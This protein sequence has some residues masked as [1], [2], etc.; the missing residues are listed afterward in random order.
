MAKKQAKP[1]KEPKKRSPARADNIASNAQG[2]ENN[3]V[4]MLS[5]R[6]VDPSSSD[7]LTNPYLSQIQRQEVARNL[8]QASGNQHLHQ[9]L[10]QLLDNGQQPD[11]VQ[12]QDG[13]TEARGGNT[14]EVVAGDSLWRIAENTYGHGRYWRQIY[15]ANP[16][17]AA[18]G[19]NLIL[20]GTLLTLPLLQVP[21]AA[22]AVPAPADG[23]TEP[24]LGPVGISTEFGNFDIYPDEFVGPLPLSV[25]SA[26]S[27]PIRQADFDNMMTR[28]TEVRDNASNL[29]IT[30]TDAFKTGVMLDLGWLMTS[31]VGQDLVREIQ[32]SAHTVTIKQGAG[33]NATSYSP[34]AD[35]YERPVSPPEAGPGANVTISYNPSILFIK[36][37]SLAWHHRPPAIGLAHEM[38]HAWTGVYGTRALYETAGVKRRELQATGLDEFATARLSEN[39]FRVA[40]GLPER[41]VY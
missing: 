11:A 14:Y 41:P 9:L 15:V 25:R 20:I 7:L 36:D 6:A 38:V 17:K 34:D 24:A 33:G 1:R 10:R 13:H 3:I 18:R 31:S 19:G 29:I 27:W 26:E 22:P 28:L 40:F 32:E 5:V 35:S 4:E 2:S 16:G 37:G 23:G 8:G 30:G 21:A 12:R 39:R